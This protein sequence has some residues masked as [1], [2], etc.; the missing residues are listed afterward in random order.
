MT[1]GILRVES[2]KRKAGKAPKNMYKKVKNLPAST[3]ITPTIL[4]AICLDNA[5]NDKAFVD[6]ELTKFDPG[7]F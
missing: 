3:E 6:G 1:E 2:P 5:L 7:A 4:E